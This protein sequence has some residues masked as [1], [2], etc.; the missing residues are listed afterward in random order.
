[1]GPGR[2]GLLA[3]IRR[4][5]RIPSMDFS[6]LFT[7]D[8]SFSHLNAGTRTRVPLRVLEFIEKER[9]WSEKNPTEAMFTGYNKLWEVHQR[10]AKFLGA[11][12][13]EI[14]LRSNVTSAFSDFLFALPELPKGEFVAT[15]WDYG[16]IVNLAKHWAKTTGQGFRVASLPPRQDWN[17]ESLA[18]AV[19]GS[20]DDKTRILLISHVAIGIG[21]RLPIQKI[22]QG[23]RKRGVIVLIDGAHAVG[24]L[25]LRLAELEAADF[26]GGNFH[27][28]FLGPEGTGFGWVNPRW[29]EKLV[30]KF[31]GWASEKAPP[32]YQNYGGGDAETA[33]RFFPGTIDRVPFVA[34]GEVLSFWQEFGAETIRARQTTLRDLVAAEAAAMGWERLSPI[35]PKMLGPLVSFRRPAE[36]EMDSVQLADR[37]YYEARVQVACPL[38][39]H[40][41]LLRFSPGIYA[42]EEEVKSAFARL[43]SWKP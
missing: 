17:E 15:N 23:A 31:G 1:M 42:S 5:G 36:W 13:E 9:R 22:A 2:A 40:V 38:A 25:P 11:N 41:P 27:K 37:L 26:Y 28:W 30:W 8:P 29:K 14:F 33:R 6:S 4:S 35:D 21:A 3:L 24:S 32:F 43:R 12:S 18:E 7:Q 19:L 10:L 34:L 20:L 16:G 39:Q